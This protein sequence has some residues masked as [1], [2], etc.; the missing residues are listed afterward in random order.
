M[1]YR[2]LN[3]AGK[4]PAL[5]QLARTVNSPLDQELKLDEAAAAIR[6]QWAT[7]Y[8]LTNNRLGTENQR[9]CSRIR[10]SKTRAR[11]QN[12]N[13]AT[14]LPLCSPWEI[15][16]KLR[17]R[18]GQGKSY[19]G[20]VAAGEDGD[21][22]GGGEGRGSGQ[23]ESVPHARRRGVA[24]GGMGA[25]QWN[26]SSFASNPSSPHL[27][28]RPRAREGARQGG[29]RSFLAKPSRPQHSTAPDRASPPPGDR[30]ASPSALP[31][32]HKLVGLVGLLKQIDSTICSRGREG[33]GGG[34]KGCVE[35]HLAAAQARLAAPPGWTGV[36]LLLVRS[37]THIFS[38]QKCIATLHIQ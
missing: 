33:E 38:R 27:M 28:P 4:L 12:P 23:M 1:E 30:R 34:V 17:V 31:A 36:S 9:Y 2:Y 11:Q 32:S 5:S 20:A 29:G 7:C 24:P 6:I 13:I 14:A 10:G 37:C 8:K 25:P 26:P 3:L 16:G 22:E 35:V 18:A 15:E 21:G 19:A